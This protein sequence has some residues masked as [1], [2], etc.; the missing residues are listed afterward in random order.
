[1]ATVER[2][3]PAA[4]LWRF[5]LAFYA[6]PGVAEALLALQDR[7]GFDVNLILYALWHGHSG[8]GRL[9]G[10]G[11]AAAERAVEQVRTEI[12]LPLRRLRRSLAAHGETDLRRLRAAI[13]KLELAA[14]KAAQR[15]LAAASGPAR[16]AAAGD[17]RQADARANFVSCLGADAAESVEAGLV[18][19]AFL[20]FADLARPAP[21]DPSP[22]GGAGSP[23][24]RTVPLSKP[25]R[26]RVR[27]RV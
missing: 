18:W 1:M 17:A 22:A 6:L 2:G 9:D 26:S 24:R 14:E 7:S 12:V 5:S 27:P 10:G 23:Q 4:G 21:H 3:G 11:F 8:R 15:R 19:R 20:E 13:L 25:K 16:A